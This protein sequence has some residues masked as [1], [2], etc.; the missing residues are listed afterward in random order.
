MFMVKEAIGKHI[1]YFK[2]PLG[3]RHVHW[4]VH[5]AA[6]G[7]HSTKLGALDP[8]QKHEQVTIVQA[9]L[10]TYSVQVAVSA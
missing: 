4:A 9:S 7:T 3:H 10:L 1:S 8:V 5:M 6:A 2:V